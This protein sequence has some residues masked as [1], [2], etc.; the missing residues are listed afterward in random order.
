MVRDPAPPHRPGPRR[1]PPPGGGRPPAAPPSRRAADQL[2]EAVLE[3]RR[4]LEEAL[5]AVQGIEARDKA[6]A[7]RIA[8]MVLRRTGSLD[9]VLEPFLSRT[10]PAPAQRALRIG[11]AELLLLGTA[12]HA[13][14]AS[15]VALVPRPL[16]GL[17][18]AVLR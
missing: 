13:A 16:A 8:A 10:P 2:L 5:D 14:V 3:L 9:A 15:A 7:H 1:G 17:V 11:A 6:A 18:N 4:P 12:P